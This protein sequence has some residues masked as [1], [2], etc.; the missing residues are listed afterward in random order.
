[1]LIT[2]HI[3]AGQQQLEIRVV[4]R[5][6]AANACGVIQHAIVEAYGSDYRRM[7]LDLRRADFDHSASLFRLHSLL[8]VFQSLILHKGVRIT[9]LFSLEYTEQW[10]S[11]DKA[12]EFDGITM[13]YF[14]NREAA[15]HFLGKEDEKLAA[16]VH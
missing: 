7:V 16:D 13:R 3:D 10:M 4:G 2:N 14:T 11:L 12:E 8:Q 1:M 15:V 5:I 9:V 6:D